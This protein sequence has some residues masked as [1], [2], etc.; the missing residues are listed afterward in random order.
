MIDAGQGSPGD[1]HQL[2]IDEECFTLGMLQNK[3]HRL[4]VETVVDRVEDATCHARGVVHFK[5][6]HAIG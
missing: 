2:G 1:G 3:G 4:S 5:R 6:R